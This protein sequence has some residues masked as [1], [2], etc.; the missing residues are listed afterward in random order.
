[1]SQSQGIVRLG[2]LSKL[3]QSNELIWI[4][5]R[6]LSACNIAAQR[7]TLQHGPQ[8]FLVFLT[9]FGLEQYGKASS[10][11]LVQIY[12]TAL[13]HVPE[14]NNVQNFHVCFCFVL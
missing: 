5:T 9:F 7:N 2:G 11:T 4:R 13:C 8:C 3:N 1:M 6:N 14:H 10:E 12:R